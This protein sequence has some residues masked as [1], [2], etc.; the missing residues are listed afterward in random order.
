ME[1]IN[2]SKESKIFVVKNMS[3]KNDGKGITI[4]TIS[5][6]IATGSPKG[7]IFSGSEIGPPNVFVKF[8]TSPTLFSL[9]KMYIYQL[10]IIL[11]F[12]M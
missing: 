10:L 1:T 7:F 8:M 9:I 3:N 6:N 2:I 12:L 11:I 4:I 5:I